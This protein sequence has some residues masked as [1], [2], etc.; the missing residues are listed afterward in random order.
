LHGVPQLLHACDGTEEQTVIHRHDDAVARIGAKKPMPSHHLAQHLVDL[1][2]TA[3]MRRANF[4]IAILVCG[5]GE[6]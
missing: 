6:P 1:L 2:W 3:L 4:G 5:K